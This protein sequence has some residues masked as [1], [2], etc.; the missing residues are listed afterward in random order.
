MKYIIIKK[1]KKILNIKYI[2]NNFYFVKKYL[3]I[4]LLFL[5]SN[6]VRTIK[7]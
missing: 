6:Y 1:N 3:D 4:H 5:F 7:T 2:R